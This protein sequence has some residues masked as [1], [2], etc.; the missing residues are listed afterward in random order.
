[1]YC[2][3]TCILHRNS[4]IHHSESCGYEL[5]NEICIPEILNSTFNASSLYLVNKLIVIVRII[6]PD[7]KM[8][9]GLVILQMMMLFFAFSTGCKTWISKFYDTGNQ[10]IFRV[11]DNDILLD[12]IYHVWEVSKYQLYLVFQARNLL[13]GCLMANA[14]ATGYSVVNIITIVLLPLIMGVVKLKPRM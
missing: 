13:A 7:N 3:C 2:Q 10:C 4:I 9:F 14:I 11:G 5:I 8:D 6:I 1:M 12:N